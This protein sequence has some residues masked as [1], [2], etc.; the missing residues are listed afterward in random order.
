MKPT[1][2]S[3]SILRNAPC[4]VK[5]QGFLDEVHQK[6]VYSAEVDQAVDDQADLDESLDDDPFMVKETFHSDDHD[7]SDTPPHILTV[8]ML[9][10]WLHLQF[11]L[12]HVACNTIL[13]ILTCILVLLSPTI[14]T[15]FTTLQS[16]N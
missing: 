2:V 3:L 13:A 5:S 7:L 6:E 14:A 1:A 16:S 10:S 15:P 9:V 11:H 8:Y 12:P 4:N